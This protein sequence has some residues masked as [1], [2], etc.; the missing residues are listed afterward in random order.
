MAENS[1]PR[2]HT[3]ENRG[4]GASESGYGS[5]GNS[6][7]GVIRGVGIAAGRLRGLVLHEFDARQVGVVNVPGPFAV[8]ADFRIV[9]RLEAVGAEARGGG[10]DFIDGEGEMILHAALLFVGTWRNVEH[11]FDPVGAIGDLDFPPVVVGVLEAAVPVHAE[12]E[13]IAIEG[14]F[15]SAVLDDEAGVDHA[16]ADLFAGR[17]EEAGGGELHEGDG[18]ALG[19]EKFEMLDAVRI[20]FDFARGDVMR[21]EV[22]AHLFEVGGGEGDFGEQICGSA[23]GYLYQLDLLAFINGVTRVGDA[24]AACGAG[25]QPENARVELARLVEVRGKDADARDPGDGRARGQVFR[26][27]REARITSSQEEEEPVHLRTNA[28]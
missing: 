14:V 19:I 23:G 15:D 16:S 26:S 5:R 17:G 20:F 12:A 9:G 10:L 2:P 7:L 24:R 25:C 3:P 22:S 8:A 28:F 6:W 13:E 27:K 21:E 18:M 1:S 4:D 11:V